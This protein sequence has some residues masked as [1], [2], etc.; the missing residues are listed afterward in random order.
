MSKYEWESGTITLPSKHV[1]PL[2]KILREHIN[3]LHTQVREIAVTL[4]KQAGTRSAKKYGESLGF[5]EYSFLPSNAKSTTNH[6]ATARYVLWSLWLTAK[7]TGTPVT[8]PTVANVS[9][10]VPKMTVKNTAFPVFSHD[11][12]GINLGSISFDG[13]RVTWS[14]HDNNHAVDDAYQ[15]EI[16]R[17]FFGYMERIEWSRGTGGYGV[18]NDEYNEEER[19]SIGGGGNYLTFSYG[20]LGVEAMASNMGVNVKEFMKNYPRINPQSH[21]S[22]NSFERTKTPIRNHYTPALRWGF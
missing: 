2:K 13:N 3:D 18:G 16:S 11:H 9:A 17:L 20:P 8:S 6:E 12:S 19:D 4:H 22:N 15:S 21:A 14:I 7:K 5:T 10:I 1:A